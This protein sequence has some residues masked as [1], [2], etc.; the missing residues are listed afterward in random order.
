M[1]L[2]HKTL[3]FFIDFLQCFCISLQFRSVFFVRYGLHRLR[4]ASA[5]RIYFFIFCCFYIDFLCV[6]LYNI[7]IGYFSDVTSHMFPQR[8]HHQQLLRMCKRYNRLSAGTGAQIHHPSTGGIPT[9]KIETKCLHA[10]YT[11]KEY[12]AESCTNSSEHYLRL[13]F[14]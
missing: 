14:N 10:G 6:L 1:S 9:M 3:T 13:R 11:P 4:Q 8:A 5:D 7:Y 2:L 12:R